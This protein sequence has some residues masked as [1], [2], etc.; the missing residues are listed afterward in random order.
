MNKT[1][2]FLVLMVGCGDTYY[3]IEPEQ[4][5][6]ADASVVIVE[7]DVVRVVT[8]IAEPAADAAAQ[9]PTTVTPFLDAGVAIP[10]AAVVADSSVPVVVDAGADAAVEPAEPEPVAPPLHFPMM[11]W[12]GAR[13]WAVES[14][15]VE[16]DYVSPYNAEFLYECTGTSIAVRERIGSCTVKP[17]GSVGAE[18]G[19]ATILCPLISDNRDAL[20]G[21]TVF[22]D[23]DLKAH[24]ATVTN[25]ATHSYV[26][27]EYKADAQRAI[28]RN[29][30]L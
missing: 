7:R 5:P 21:W 26:R 17:I 22:L 11:H 30:V 19:S 20:D 16:C 13:M 12:T 15:T 18:C 10:D 3:E 14:S 23:T 1:I 29:K 4:A 28:V 6:V 25:T 24:T 2:A 27:C 8:L 9:P